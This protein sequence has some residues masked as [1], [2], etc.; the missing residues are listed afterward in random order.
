MYNA[1]GFVA[2][3][4]TEHRDQVSHTADV[5]VSDYHGPGRDLRLEVRTGCEFGATNLSQY[6]PA[7]FWTGKEAEARDDHSPHPVLPF[8]VSAAGGLGPSAAAAIRELGRRCPHTV[9]PSAGFSWT[10]PGHGKYWHRYIRGMALAGW[11]RALRASF[12]QGFEE[13]ATGPVFEPHVPVQAELDTELAELQAGLG[14]GRP[15]VVVEACPACGESRGRCACRCSACGFG[16][17]GPGRWPVCAASGC[18]QCRACCS[19]FF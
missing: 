5:V 12:G 6:G 7:G 13:A 10:V 16:S 17:S 14:S 4:G 11:A 9:M 2:V 3:L 19:C 18:G 15:R 8:V 1:H